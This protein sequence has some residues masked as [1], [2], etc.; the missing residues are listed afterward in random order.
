MDFFNIKQAK[1]L[2]VDDQPMYLKLLHDIL[3]DTFQTFVATS[4]EDAIAFCKNNLPDMILMDIEMPG[5]NGI[6]TCRRIKGEDIL[7]EIPVIFMSAHKEPEEENKCWDVGGVDFIAKPFNHL[8]L[9]NR[10][11]S[12]L[13]IK[14]QSDIL[15]KNLFQDGL[16]GLSNRQYLDQELEKELKRSSRIKTNLSLAFMDVDFFKQFN[17]HYGHLKGD[18]CLKKLGSLM[19]LS[20]SRPADI[21]AR[22]G[23]EEFVMVLPD[24][25]HQGAVSKVNQ[26]VS[27]LAEQ[28]IPHQKSVVSEYVTV[29]IGLLTIVPSQGVS[30]TELY[31]K[32]DGLLYQAKDAGRNRVVSLDYAMC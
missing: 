23:G 18:E 6:E 13:T 3:G 28:R 32:A 7:F 21:A 31:E 27:E 8:T 16:T 29:S 14:F 17:D 19:K 4:G 26:L 1:I 10:I 15:K 22:Y 5:L 12:H 30:A 20:L 2:L 25:N 11:R 24:T 9:L